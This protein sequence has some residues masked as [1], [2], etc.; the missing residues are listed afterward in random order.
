V[1]AP[2]PAPTAAPPTRTPTRPRQ[3]RRRRLLLHHRR[4]ARA[5]AVAWLLL[6]ILLRRLT[7]AGRGEATRAVLQGAPRSLP[8]TSARRSTSN[9]PSL[10]AA[11]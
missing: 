3:G 9:G 8:F 2:I 6:G 4:R 7:T 5:A 1:F 11:R 10:R